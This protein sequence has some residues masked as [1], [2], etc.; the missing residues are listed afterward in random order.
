MFITLRKIDCLFPCFFL[1]Y[2]SSCLEV[3]SRKAVL[4]NFAK[5]RGKHSRW[6]PFSVKLLAESQQLYSKRF[7]PR[8]LPC[9]FFENFQNSFFTLHLWTA[10][11]EHVQTELQKHNFIILGSRYQ[12][13]F[14]KINVFLRS[15]SF[16]TQDNLYLP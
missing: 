12:V 10:A 5:F 9:E 8:T 16:E 13:L 11:S 7:P 3:F 6:G 4:K 1:I 15:V 2:R 14:N